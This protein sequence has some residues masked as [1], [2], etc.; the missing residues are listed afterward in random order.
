MVHVGRGEAEVVPVALTV[1]VVVT[2]EVAVAEA[3]AQRE[4]VEV[5]ERERVFVTVPLVERVGSTIVLEALRAPEVLGVLVHELVL[6]P[7]GDC[8]VDGDAR[9]L[10]D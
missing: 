3:V 1:A 8:R 7:L 9:A 10:R 5:P 2:L 4:G 6:G